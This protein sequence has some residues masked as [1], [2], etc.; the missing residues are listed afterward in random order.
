MIPRR[1]PVTVK[2]SSRLNHT[3]GAA[4][5][6]LMGLI[7][8]QILSTIMVYLSNA[9]LYQTMR[10]I[11]EAGY[12]SI[13]NQRTLDSLREF[14]PAVFGGLFFTLSTGAVLSISAL[15]AVWVWDRLLSRNRFSLIVLVLPW[16]G[17]LIGINYRGVN[18]LIT[19]VFLVVPLIVITATLKWMSPRSS[20]SA[21]LKALTFFIPIALLAALWA[22]QLDDR[23]FL[24]IR[25]KI[26]L[27]NPVGT[28]INDFYYQYTLYPAEVFKSLDQKIIRTC[29]IDPI[30]EKSL[31]EV[32]EKKLRFHDYLKLDGHDPVDLKIV[33]E[34]SILIFQNKEKRVLQIPIDDFLSRPGA[35][36]KKF[37]SKSDRHG[38]FRQFTFFS[39]LIGFPVTL[40]FFLYALLHHIS[41]FFLD[42][43]V[44]RIV[45]GIV[46]FSIGA[47][48][49]VPLYQD[50]GAPVDAKGLAVALESERLQE[51][52]AALQVMLKK[53]MEIG[54]IRAYGKIMTSAHI[55]ERY[56]FVRVLGA[57]RK[58]ESY[59]D[60]LT[61]LDDPQPNV[62][63][64]AYF[65]LENR[66]NKRA[67]TEIIKRIKTIDHWYVQWYAYKA[68]RALGWKQTR[69]K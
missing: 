51:R 8:S 36:L 15:G 64:M 56:W 47:S 67:V 20:D 69:S 52:V 68:L 25:D 61:F 50:K 60:L 65:A 53:R 23:M 11:N 30:R 33:R 57:S 28:K 2:N 7:I 63:G 21:G 9:D 12:L 55:V 37:S 18:P 59:R 19:S 43:G 40:Y 16:V 1:T 66:K 35:V 31:K 22:L 17:C 48:L 5:I 46:C 41:F 27:S 54:N 14:G 62:A 24:D 39:L 26:L 29:N 34:D 10:A 58:P 32:L 45:A 42:A 3:T 6:L 38:F 44:S 49:W 4:G 13:P